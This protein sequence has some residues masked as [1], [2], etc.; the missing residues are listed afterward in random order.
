MLT[1]GNRATHRFP[2]LTLQAWM[3]STRCLNLVGSAVS[4]GHSKH[5]GPLFQSSHNFRVIGS[6]FS[7]PPCCH[8]PVEFGRSHEL[9]SKLVERCEVRQAGE[10][11][12]VLG[13]QGLLADGERLLK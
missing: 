11:D 6:Q 9:A 7:F 13:S 10:T 3:V 8:L 1:A 12:R 5:R 4:L 2:V